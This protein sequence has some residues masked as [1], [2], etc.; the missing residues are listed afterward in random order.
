[1][2]L[3]KLVTGGVFDKVLDK[4][5]PDKVSQEEKIKLTQAFELELMANETKIEEYRR[6]MIVADAESEDSYVSRSRPTLF[7]VIYLTIIFNYMV[8]PLVQTFKGIAIA[9]IE[10]PPKLWELFTVGYLGYSGFRTF[11]KHSK[12]KH[13]N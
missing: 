1:M 13:S 10:L 9:P 2:N 6:D 4:V 12:N 5:L 11:D 3:L 7:Y 8:I